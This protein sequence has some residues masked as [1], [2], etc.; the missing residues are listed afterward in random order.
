MP[1]A[2]VTTSASGVCPGTAATINSGLS[3]GN[4]TVAPIAIGMQPVPSSA[5]T[6]V[7]D[8]AAVVPQT[9]VSLDDGGWA[10]LPI[11]FTFN[12]FGNNHTT[13]NIGTN[14]TVH[15]GTYSSAALTDFTFTTFPSLLEPASVIGAACHDMNFAAS[16]GAL[17]GSIKYW[18]Q[19]YAPNRRFIVQYENVRAYNTAGATAKYTT[20][21]IHLLETLGTVEVHVLQSDAV[22]YTKVVGLQDQTRTIGAVALATSASITNLAWRFSPP[23]N[24]STIWTANGE[25]IASGTN[26]FTQSVSP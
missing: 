19:G 10:A 20:N 5:V 13:I 21:Q 9:S 15:L 12:Y 1:S 8:G 16:A 3:A 11:G 23:S 17:N 18:T 2:T 22:S 7:A 14:A 25:Q 24:F 26:I 4:F 6:L